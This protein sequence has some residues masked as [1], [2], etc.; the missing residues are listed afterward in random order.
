MAEIHPLNVHAAYI[1][2]VAD[3][4]E[5]AGVAVERWH[6]DPNEPRDGAITLAGY[7]SGEQRV[8]GW[9]E[10]S[11][12]MYGTGP[13]GEGL[14]LVWWIGDGVLPEPGAVV[15][16]V[17]QCLAGDYSAASIHHRPRYRSFE[18]DDDLDEQMAAYHSHA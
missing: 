5:K 18:E 3:A 8:A 1:N 16:A 9:N 4:L 6:A 7:E 17:Q 12:W 2:A 15:S 10:E 14:T 11:G 13:E